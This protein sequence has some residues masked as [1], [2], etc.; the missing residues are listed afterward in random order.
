MCVLCSDGDMDVLRVRLTM[1][2]LNS[3][4]QKLLRKIVCLYQPKQSWE[5]HVI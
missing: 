1:Y 2:S 5:H 3:S 4:F